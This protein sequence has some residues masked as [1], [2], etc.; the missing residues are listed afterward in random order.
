MWVLSGRRDGIYSR[1]YP[2]VCNPRDHQLTCSSGWHAG[3]SSSLLIGEP[4]GCDFCL[5]ALFWFYNLLV[6]LVDTA[7]MIVFHNQSSFIKLLTILN[8]DNNSSYHIF[9][10]GS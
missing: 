4:G 1:G 10:K 7:R 8:F 2:R 6:L 9:E 5:I 3:Q